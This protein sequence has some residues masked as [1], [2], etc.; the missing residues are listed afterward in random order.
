MVSVF[1]VRNEN[2][3]G[4]IDMAN[5]TLREQ[6]TSMIGNAV[7]D[8]LDKDPDTNIPKLMKWWDKFDRDNFYEVQRN[9]IRKVVEDPDNVW[10]RY[11]KS[12]WTDIDPDVRKTLFRN[13]I[14]QTFFIGNKRQNYNRENIIATFHGLF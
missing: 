3:G 7:L 12:F 8:Y 10:Y 13:L 2:S 1:E 14:V 4:G 11:I 5:K 6:A 9:V